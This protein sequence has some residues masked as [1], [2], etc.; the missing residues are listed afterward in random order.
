ME[1]AMPELEQYINGSD[2]YDPLIQAVLVHYPFETIHP[3]LDDNRHIGR[4][5][6]L[7]YLIERKL[8]SKPVIYVSCFLKQNQIEYYDRI[9][10]VRRSG[11]H[12][13]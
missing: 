11:N 10:K 4:L 5:R 8:L 2:T 3:F 6:S 1:E 9:S 13:R 12:E 7:L